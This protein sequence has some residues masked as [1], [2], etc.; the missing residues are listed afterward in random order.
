MMRQARDAALNVPYRKRRRAHTVEAYGQGT[1][2]RIK[3]PFRRLIRTGRNCRF[4]RS[5]FR[6]LHATG[7]VSLWLRIP[8][9]MG[10]GV[11]FRCDSSHAGFMRTQGSGKNTTLPAS[12]KSKNEADTVQSFNHG[13]DVYPNNIG[14]KCLSTLSRTYP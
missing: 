1:A 9:T 4:V 12:Y 14:S 10:G 8:F 6:T 13:D 11:S 2:R 5:A 7:A 3:S